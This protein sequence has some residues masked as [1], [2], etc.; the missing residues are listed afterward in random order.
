MLTYGQR[1]FVLIYERIGQKVSKNRISYNMLERI[2]YFWPA[3]LEYQLIVLPKYL[4]CDLEL[5]KESHCKSTEKL[6]QL[7]F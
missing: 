2:E 3:C 5:K 7:M 1:I 6:P 4:F